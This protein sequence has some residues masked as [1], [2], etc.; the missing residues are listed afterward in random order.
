[1]NSNNH[2]QEKRRQHTSEIKKIL[3]GLPRLGASLLLGIETFALYTLYNVGYNL[4]TFKIG[5]ALALGY[6]SVASGQFLLGWISDAKY[7]K[8]GRR[9]PYILLFTPL[10]GLSFIFL[11]IP[12][13]FLPDI[14]DKSALFIWLLVWDMLFRFSYAATTPYQAWMAEV[15]PVHE[16]PKV[17]QIQNIFGYIGTGL[18]GFFTFFILTASLNQIGNPPSSVPEIVIIFIIIFGIMSWLLFYVLVFLIKK[19]PHYEID[20]NLIENLRNIFKNKNYLSFVVLQGI[21][22]IAWVIIS[23]A[24]LNFNLE[25]FDLTD[26][27]F[28]VVVGFLAIAILSFLYIWRKLIRSRGKKSTLKIILLF[29]TFSLNLTLFR[30]FLTNNSVLYGIIFMICIGILLGGWYLFPYIAFADLA[31]D[32]EKKSGN[33]RAGIYIGFPSI[34]L[35]AS[36]AFGIFMLGFL[37]S[38]YFP[39]VNTG[40]STFSIGWVLWGPICAL[41]LLISYFY[42]KKY[43]K[44]DFEWEENK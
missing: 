24:M 13:L 14:T 33:L 20:T 32:D 9:K 43:V 35:N 21:S 17:S 27:E 36:Q 38:D 5:I 31:E 37:T 16:R 6:L 23:S 8:L 7:T 25:V 40:S 39:T 18:N 1:M 19:E 22:G 42:L 3:F 11:M 26:V 28:I 2:V 15:F 41:V 4:D 44:L 10:F 12:P 29:G 30:L 34:L